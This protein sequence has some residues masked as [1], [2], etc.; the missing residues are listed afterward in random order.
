MFVCAWRRACGSW[1]PPSRDTGESSPSGPSLL[2]CVRHAWVSVSLLRG[3]TKVVVAE[4]VVVDPLR[5]CH[6]QKQDRHQARQRP[7][8][9]SHVTALCQDWPPHNHLC[10][11]AGLQ[12]NPLVHVAGAAATRS[13]R[14]SLAGETLRGTQCTTD[15]SSYR[16]CGASVKPDSLFSAYAR[17]ITTPEVEKGPALAAIR[18]YM[19][20]RCT[21]S[22]PNV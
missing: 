8:A 3:K 18:K 1:V 11:R 17:A 12:Q 4:N 21:D 6:G 2:A 5:P 7:R 10:Q 22:A 9:L 15:G 14:S 19:F 13:W 20:L 16:R